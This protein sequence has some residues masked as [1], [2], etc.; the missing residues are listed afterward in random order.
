MNKA[1]PQDFYIGNVLVK[2]K[3]HLIIKDNT[4]IAV[5]PLAMAMLL[6]LAQKQGKILSNDELFDELW[7]GRIVTDNALYRVVRHLRKALGDKAS[8][9]QF[10]RTVKKSGYVLISEVKPTKIAPLY[11]RAFSVKS[12]ITQINS[13]L[14]IKKIMVSCSLVGIIVT[15]VIYNTQTAPVAQIMN[16]RQL[17]SLPGLE[18]QPIYWNKSNSIIFTHQPNG[19]LFNNIVVQSLENGKYNYLTDDYLHYLNLSLSHDGQY[20]AF[21]QRDDR[22]CWI[23]YL[24]I[25]SNNGEFNPQKL[26][27]CPFNGNSELTWA[28]NENLLYFKKQ[29]LDY[30]QNQIVQINIKTKE[31]TKLLSNI[32]EN[33]HDFLPIVEPGGHRL[34]YIRF[35]EK[36]MQIRLFDKASKLDSLI[37]EYNDRNGLQDITWYSGKSALLLST[38]N[39]LK[40]L[41]LD[42]AL[43]PV[44]QQPQKKLNK[45]SINNNG[46]L[47]YVFK[48][49]STKLSE[50]NLSDLSKLPITEHQDGM[51]VSL[52]VKSESAGKYS[53][54]AKSILFISDRENS[55]KRLWLKQKN[56]TT[57]LSDEAI[58][59]QPHWSADNHKILYVTEQY[60]VK[61][62]DIL[63]GQSN[64]LSEE[65]TLISRAIW[66]KDNGEIYFSRLHN[67]K[68]QLF[69]MLIDERQTIKITTDGAY[70]MQY[71]AEDNYLYYNKYD[72]PGLWRYDIE[73][74]KE[75]LLF[76]DFNKMNGVQWQAFE[77]GIYYIR[78][79]SGLRGLFYYD[80]KKQ[81]QFTLIDN[82]ETIFFDISPDQSKVLLSEKKKLTGNIYTADLLK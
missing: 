29:S 53:N 58:I 25:G 1:E 8:N 77:S 35:L 45:V 3:H 5:E 7:Q 57:L 39:G 54:D 71:V 37:I 13:F 40:I 59:G 41:S 49:Y 27:E 17:T 24:K 73:N 2:P 55:K 31:E 52:S 16:D 56:K 6:L 4:N 68:H 11:S 62:L 70:Y 26:T 46:K 43:S 47:M 36:K 75:Q 82:K 23:K 80:F 81:K 19:E 32:P 74:K 21:E 12:I 10:I 64:F 42:G 79:A 48:D 61:S 78:D 72:L 63:T 33:S 30:G 28:G 18:Y 20:L 60:R 38:N 65:N 22:Q 9:P 66:G 50:H 34:A 14:R 67:G 15:A 76:A 69:K 44:E 51:E